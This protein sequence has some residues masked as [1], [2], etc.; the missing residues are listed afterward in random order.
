MVQQ[1]KEKKSSF[2]KGE[3]RKRKWKPRKNGPFSWAALP[4]RR[5]LLALRT[6]KSAIS[7]FNFDVRLFFLPEL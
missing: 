4:H 7:P 3:K 6:G 1:R 5:Y 2:K